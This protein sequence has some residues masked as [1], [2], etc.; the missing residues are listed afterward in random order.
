[1]NNRAVTTRAP[2]SLWRYT[3]R[4]AEGICSLY[5]DSLLVEVS[6]ELSGHSFPDVCAVEKWLKERLKQ[7]VTV[8]SLAVECA[9][10]WSCKATVRGTAASHGEILS[11]CERS[12]Q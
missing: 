2:L 8:E 4:A 10:A 7:P 12:L 1:M 6:L 9:L 5:G 11:F 3:C